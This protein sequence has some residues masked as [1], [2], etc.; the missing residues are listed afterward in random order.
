MN[1]RKYL[2]GVLEKIETNKVSIFG[3]RMMTP[4]LWITV[5]VVVLAL[6]GFREDDTINTLTVIIVSM[7]AGCFVGIVSFSQAAEK[8]W[9]HIAHHIDKGSIEARIEDLGT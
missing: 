6:L 8:H 2:Q 5:A 1:E 3:R 4:I 9:P 7:L